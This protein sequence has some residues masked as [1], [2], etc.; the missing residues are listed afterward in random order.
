MYYHHQHKKC[1]DNPHPPVNKYSRP[2]EFR[3]SKNINTK[4]NN[5]LEILTKTMIILLG[6]RSV[7]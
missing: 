7:K 4:S 5:T 1:Q 2:R 3:L 6:R